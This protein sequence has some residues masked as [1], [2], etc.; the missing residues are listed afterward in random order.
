MVSVPSS[1]VSWFL[2]LLGTTEEQCKLFQIGGGAGAWPCGYARGGVRTRS[3]NPMMEDSARVPP[4]YRT[5]PIE[6]TKD[7]MSSLALSVSDADRVLLLIVWFHINSS[8]Y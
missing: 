7:N 1:T 4:E 5:E 8:S 2:G 6:K 3:S